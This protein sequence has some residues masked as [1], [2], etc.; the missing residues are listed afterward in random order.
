MIDDVEAVAEA[1]HSPVVVHDTSRFA[2]AAGP[3]QTVVLQ[4]AHHVIKRLSVVGV[5][6]VK[7]AQGML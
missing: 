7:L 4:S 1:D 6:L 3:I 5:H 2:R